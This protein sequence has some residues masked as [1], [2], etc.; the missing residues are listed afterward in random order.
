M[1]LP[2]VRRIIKIRVAQPQPPVIAEM[3]CVA[4]PDITVERHLA[5]N[6]RRRE[7]GSSLSGIKAGADDGKVAVGRVGVKKHPARRKK[8]AEDQPQEAGSAAGTDNRWRLQIGYEL[9][10]AA[11]A[12][13]GE[14]FMC[15]V[16]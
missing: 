7:G 14:F 13:R 4:V 16:G 15:L 9:F 5:E 3:R 1:N 12:E 10:F 2:A 11:H 8:D 6:Y